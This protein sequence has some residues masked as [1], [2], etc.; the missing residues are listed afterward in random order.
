MAGIGFRLREMAVRKTF[1]EWLKLYTYSAV[2]FSGPW[3][4][5]IMALAALSV[6]ALPAMQE[7][8]VRLFT[9]T[10][11]YAYCFSLIAT[12]VIQLVVTRYVSDQF[13]LR[14]PDAVVP[15]FVGAIAVTVIFQTATG[16]IALFF[17]DF[18]FLYKVVALG[19]YVAVSVIW[20]EMLFLSAAKDYMNIVIAFAVAYLLSFVGAQALGA[21]FKL[22]GLA[23]GF[24]IG[25]VLLVVLL[26]HRIFS[27]YRFGKGFDF[28]FMG[29]FKKF[30][31]LA[32]AG[33]AYNLAIWV[34]KVILWYSPSGL[35]IHSYFYT[36]FPYDSA[37]FIG[38]V[39]I[40]P[41]LSIF[42][43]RIETDF[44]LRYKNYYGTILQK[45]SLDLILQR[46]AEMLEVLRQ[47]MKAVVI[48]QGSVTLGLFIVM[49][50]LVALLGIDPANTPVFRVAILGAFFHGG[51]LVLM[52]LMLYFDFRGAG[53][54]LA[55]TFLATNISFTL[56]TTNLGPAW[57]GWGYTFSTFVS[58]LAGVI[59]FANRI[60]NLEY[61]TFMRQ[62][63]R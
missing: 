23:I 47:A 40:V 10:I 46:K 18:D 29:Y 55:T 63:L 15:T 12:G 53:L 44:Y 20:V 52:I 2:I 5:S 27:E 49:P 38:Y 31:T 33:L 48:Y 56:V 6:F 13:Y 32:G 61:L 11:V 51:L 1:A 45:A 21:I 17:A 34:D 60:K 57:L 43:L 7:I 22:H 59:I 25:Q 36:H 24:L 19:I 62:P 37:M 35:H 26:M 16:A 14:N 4:I 39:S 58:L 3:L 9:V 54:I 28:A 8:D 42:L 50:F 30:P 41:T